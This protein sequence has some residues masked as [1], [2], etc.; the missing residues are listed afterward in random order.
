M[1]EGMFAGEGGYVLKPKGYRPNDIE[2]P[3]KK[4]LD[5][6]IEFFAGAELPMPEEDDTAK[7]FK[8]YVKVELHVGEASGPKGKTR[9]KRGIECSWEGEKVAFTGVKGVVDKLGFVRFKVHDEEFGRDDLAAWACI[10]LDRLQEG[11]RFLSLFDNKG[12]RSDGHILVKVT[13]RLY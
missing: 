5:L 2:G 10:R 6:S 13:K 3:V 4:T 11:Y 7:G 1:N 8:P 9:A 12:D